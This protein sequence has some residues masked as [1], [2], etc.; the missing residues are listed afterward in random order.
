MSIDIK[1]EPE[2]EVRVNGNLLKGK[3]LE[4]FEEWRRCED[5]YEKAK[6]KFRKL[7]WGKFKEVKTN[8]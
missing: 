3:V 5:S 4:A 6:Q 8:E 7:Y 1:Y 2:Y